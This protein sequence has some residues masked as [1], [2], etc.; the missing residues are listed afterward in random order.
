MARRTSSGGRRQATDGLPPTEPNLP[1]LAGFPA[2]HLEPGADYDATDFVDLDLSHQDASDARF[3]E[4]RLC[5]CRLDGVSLQRTRI[6]DSLLTDNQAASLD[7]ADST[8]RQS[9]L[10]DGRLGSVVLTG[11]TW[12]GIRVRDTRLGFVNLAG[13]RLESVIFERCEIGTLDLRLA[14][15]RSVTFVDCSLETLDIVGASLQDVDLTGA[16][17]RSLAGVESLRGSV[18]TSGQLLELAPV[19]AAELGIA[20]RED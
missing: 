9:V 17:L 2:A 1:V 18:I 15:L 14:E 11:A 4:C 6:I 13:A 5:R 12:S 20:I 7:L 8:W 3:L 16:T 10:A 19:L